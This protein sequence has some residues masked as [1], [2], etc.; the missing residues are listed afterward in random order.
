MWSKESIAP[1][2]PLPFY[3]WMVVLFA[4][5]WEPEEGNRKEME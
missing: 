3:P 1:T 2:L 4:P 5:A